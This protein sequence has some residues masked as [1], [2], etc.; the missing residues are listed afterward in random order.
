MK[1]IQYGDFLGLNHFILIYIILGRNLSDYQ[2]PISRKAL[3]GKLLRLK[4]TFRLVLLLSHISR[5]LRRF[6]SSNS[7]FRYKTTDVG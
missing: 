7:V 4:I 1:S 5:F 6:K 3:I 2:I